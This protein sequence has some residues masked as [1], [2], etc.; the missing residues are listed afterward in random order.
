MP[1][2]TLGDNA[3]HHTAKQLLSCTQ[4]HQSQES[5]VASMGLDMAL[6]AASPDMSEYEVCSVALLPPTPARAQSMPVRV[7][8]T[9]ETPSVGCELLTLQAS[10][11]Y[12]PRLR[13]AEGCR[14]Q[15]P[16]GM[17]SPHRPEGLQ[18]LYEPAMDTVCLLGWAPGLLILSFR[19]TASLANIR[20]DLSVRLSIS[21]QP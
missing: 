4:K 20:A 3:A 5:G 21:R 10:T 9:A 7:A 8:L 16:Q 15:V 11:D 18:V 12:N 2:T 13:L 1:T 17:F 6:Q 14:Q 19:G